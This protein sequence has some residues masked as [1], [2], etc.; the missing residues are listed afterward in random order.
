MNPDDETQNFMAL[1]GGIIL[2]LVVLY[3]AF[4]SVDTLGL[5]TQIG[6]ANV[7]S[8][9]YVSSGT[10]YVTRIVNNRSF[11]TPQQTPEMYLLELE[12]EGQTVEA[13]VT[14]Q[15]Y[16]SVTKSSKVQTNYQVRRFTKM[17]QITEVQRANI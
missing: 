7:I 14:K 1:L 5:K 8:K 2:A 13:A 6:T 9:K 10:T 17:L 12:L 11:V 4:L 15:L 16:D 3:Y